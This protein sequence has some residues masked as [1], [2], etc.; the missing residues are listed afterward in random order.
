MSKSRPGNTLR[1]VSFD[2]IGLPVL[3]NDNSR[4]PIP[5]NAPPMPTSEKNGCAF[6]CM[7]VMMGS[8]KIVMP[9][10]PWTKAST[11]VGIFPGVWIER[12]NVTA[13]N[14]IMVKIRYEV[15]NEACCR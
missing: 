15:L 8:R 10:M 14:P 2:K 7:D 13:A 6:P 4:P 3:R 1:I 11:M 9:A 5:I 12:V